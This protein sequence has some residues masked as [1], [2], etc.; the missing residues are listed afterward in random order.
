MRIKPLHLT[1][2]GFCQPAGFC[3]SRFVVA[4]TRGRK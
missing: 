2:A 3:P 1:A 4:C